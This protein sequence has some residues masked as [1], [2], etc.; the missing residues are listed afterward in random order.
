MNSKTLQDI[1]KAAA[2]SEQG[3]TFINGRD[4]DRRL[5][6]RALY[7]RALAL[8]ERL[9]ALS[10]KR[11]DMVIFQVKDN[12]QFISLFWAS[13]LGGMVPV[14]VTTGNSGENFKKLFAVYERVGEA[15]L[16]TDRGLYDQLA[17][18]AAA[19]G[20][21][22]W[23]QWLEEQT[24][25]TESLDFR[26]F[27]E[28]S[29]LVEPVEGDELAFI[30]FSSGST[31]L[32]KGV[33]ITHNNLLSNMG[34]I[35][36]GSYIDERDRM[37]SWMPL[38]HDMGLIAVHLTA[39]HAAIDQYL[40]PSML[41]IRKPGLWLDRVTRYKA[42]LLYSPN[43]GYKYLLK[44]LPKL[45]H[46]WDLSSVR[47][48]YNGAEP[49]SYNLCME[50]C[51]SLA[52]FGLNQRAMYPV[53]GLAEGTI[54]VTMPVPGEDVRPIYVERDSLEMGREVRVRVNDGAG[55][56]LFVEVGRAVESCQVRVTDSGGR[57][58]GSNMVGNVEIR[59]ESVSGG[60]YND[61]EVSAETINGE[62]WL[63]TG[64]LGFM[65]CGRLVIT[66]RA[67]DIIF[68][69][70][71]NYYSHDLERLIEEKLPELS[72]SVV[73]FAHFDRESA[74]DRV[75]AAIIYRKSD[76]A[77]LAALAGQLRGYIY[78]QLGLRIGEIIPIS[79]IPK[80]TSGKVQRYKIKKEY[81][82]GEYDER[83]AALREATAPEAEP[84]SRPEQSAGGLEETIISIVA[85][86]VEHQ[87]FAAETPFFELGLDSVGAM[88][89]AAE[90]PIEGEK[91]SL[92]EI[93]THPSARSLASFLMSRPRKEPGKAAAPGVAKREFTFNRLDPEKGEDILKVLSKL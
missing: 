77:E 52:P 60:Y 51:R 53:Y 7:G 81:E 28:S 9:R 8:L 21:K 4:E 17:G 11:G 2:L 57:P 67:K 24:I 63:K 1:I 58:L 88:K 65:R 90:L 82:Q 55:C 44:H 54:A 78:E 5:S 56:A 38:T 79:S 43:F 49:I 73:V 34:A 87:P 64:D 15:F 50:F 62:G 75:M 84:V 6:Y 35:V 16:F 66:G 92:E 76:M 26:A 25:L 42:T 85:D 89:L 46:E 29:S 91:P 27:S 30:Q 3:V 59:G 22:D 37:I 80:T 10:V 61:R 41:F 33:M 48:I 20:R 47:V 93:Y 32:P 18:Y 23:T 31:G 36:Q 19:E 69:N 74:E 12:E 70:G 45:K 14:P 40:M 68:M 13:V 72:G 86:I 83:L 39:I 71:T